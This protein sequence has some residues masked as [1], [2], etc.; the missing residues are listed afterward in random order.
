MGRGERDPQPVAYSALEQLA[1]AGVEE[2]CVVL[3]KGKRDVAAALGDGSQ[4]RVALTYVLTPGTASAVHTIDLARPFVGAARVALVWPDV[5]YEPADALARTVARLT[6]SRA[7]VSLGVFPT[8]KGARF[9]RV[10]LDA[11][12]FVTGL[13]ADLVASASPYTWAL[14]A[15]RPRFTEFL[16]ADLA[17]PPT[18]TPA[19]EPA[20][21]DVLEAALADGMRIAATRLDDATFVDIGTPEDLARVRAGGS[22][23][24]S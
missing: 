2:A 23:S 18:A 20:M 16:H 14:A 24:T 5:L 22:D 4:A 17:K 9:D 21:N 3:R 19:R 8:T 15:W 6:D 10:E 1:R 11:N 13:T 12:D 7:D